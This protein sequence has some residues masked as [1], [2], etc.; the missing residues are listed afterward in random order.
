MQVAFVVSPLWKAAC[1]TLA[2]ALE[3]RAG[4]EGAGVAKMLE[5]RTKTLNSPVMMT[6]SF[7]PDGGSLAGVQ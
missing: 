1:I 4:A 3:H 7:G 2:G 5:V 6:T